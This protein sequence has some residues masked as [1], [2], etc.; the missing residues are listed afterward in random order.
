MYLQLGRCL[1]DPTWQTQKQGGA[2]MRRML[3]GMHARARWTVDLGGCEDQ[4]A[5]VLAIAHLFVGAAVERARAAVA[6]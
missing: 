5:G 3:V 1:A 2:V 4:R 6:A